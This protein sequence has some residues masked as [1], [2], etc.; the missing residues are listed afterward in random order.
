MA[1][2]VSDRKRNAGKNRRTTNRPKRT[3]VQTGTLRIPKKTHVPP[4][5]AHLTKQNQFRQDLPFQVMPF[6]KPGVGGVDRRLPS[7]NT[8]KIASSSARWAG[9]GGGRGGTATL[10][11]SCL[12]GCAKKLLFVL[13][14]P[15]L[16]FRE[17]HQ[18]YWLGCNPKYVRV[19][20]HQV[21]GNRVDTIA[22]NYSGAIGS[23]KHK[24][25]R[26]DYR[27]YYV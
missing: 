21:G 6:F 11:K 19:W 2:V 8:P 3:S 9:P 23:N 7:V 13:S 24:S 1:S 12:S 16:H 15:N 5:D 4:N 18:T 27:D 25:I 20:P 17:L 10:S 14:A 26:K 22:L